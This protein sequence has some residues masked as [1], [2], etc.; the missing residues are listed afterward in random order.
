MGAGPGKGR[1]GLSRILALRDM[2]AV[3]PGQ[4][5]DPQAKLPL[6]VEVDETWLSIGGAL[7]EA[8]MQGRVRPQPEVGDLLWHLV[9]CWH[10]LVRS[11]GNPKASASTNRLEGWFGRF[12]PRAHLTRGLKTGTGALNFVRLMAR[13]QYQR[14]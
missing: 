14:D 7:R 13:N 6:W 10:D 8:V 12:K 2:Q 5:P 3:A 9:E 1:G 4:A 11:Q